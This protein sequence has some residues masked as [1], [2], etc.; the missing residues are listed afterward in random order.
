[1]SDYFTGTTTSLPYD[2]QGK[3]NRMSDAMVVLNGTTPYGYRLVHL[4]RDGEA[5]VLAEHRGLIPEYARKTAGYMGTKDKDIGNV[6][7]LWMWWQPRERWHMGQD[8][9][10]I[11]GGLD[12]MLWR[13]EDG[14]KFSEALNQARRAFIREFGFLP[15]VALTNIKIKGAPKVVRADGENN[16][17]V[18]LMVEGWVPAMCIYLIRLEGYEPGNH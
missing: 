13:I 8:V 6:F 18:E 16:M 11:P 14:Q 1:M 7:H 17:V 10:R 9:C 2:T 15:N 4:M 3:G 5:P 12:G